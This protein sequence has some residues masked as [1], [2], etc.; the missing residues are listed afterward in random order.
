MKF[1]F[2]AIKNLIILKKLLK[3]NFSEKRDEMRQ[4]VTQPTINSSFP[5]PFSTFYL[6]IVRKSFKKRFRKACNSKN[7]DTNKKPLIL[8]KILIPKTTAAF[9]TP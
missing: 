4:K 7:F 9:P 8:F 3:E 2:I 1:V 6:T 5:L